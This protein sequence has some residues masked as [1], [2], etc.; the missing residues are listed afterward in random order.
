MQVLLRENSATDLIALAQLTDETY[1]YRNHQFEIP[2]RVEKNGTTKYQ[3]E[4]C[5]FEVE[6]E[7][8]GKFPSWLRICYRS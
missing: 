1:Q 4:M 2:V 3:A 5:G 7:E 8:K 6:S